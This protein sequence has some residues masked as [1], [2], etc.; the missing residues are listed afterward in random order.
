MKE[1]IIIGI[2]DIITDD[3]GFTYIDL[4]L[5]DGSLGYFPNS[6]EILKTFSLGSKVKYREIIE[7]NK[8]PKIIGLLHNKKKINKNLI[9]NLDALKINRSILV[10]KVL[11]IYNHYLGNR[12]KNNNLMK[13]CQLK[14]QLKV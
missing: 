8:K 6:E 14:L 3:Y 13:A 10:N 4:E 5:E 9:A 11:K 7:F 2:S 1:T 12:D